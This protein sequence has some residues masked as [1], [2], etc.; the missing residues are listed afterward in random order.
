MLIGIFLL[1][2][3]HTLWRDPKLRETKTKYRLPWQ[4]FGLKKCRFFLILTLRACSTT[5]K[6][7][8]K[9]LRHLYRNL[10][11][12]SYTNLGLYVIKIREQDKKVDSFIHVHGWQHIKSRIIHERILH[13]YLE[14]Q[15]VQCEMH[16]DQR[17]RL[18]WLAAGTQQLRSTWF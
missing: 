11:L 9:L 8:F 4:I 16:F 12:Y 5:T 18:T 14:M 17:L 7:Y 6:I 13:S 3:I 10:G 15:W 1:Y 2:C